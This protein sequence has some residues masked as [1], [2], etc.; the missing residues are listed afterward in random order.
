MLRRPPQS[1]RTDNSFPTR[2]SSDL[3]RYTG[4]VNEIGRRIAAVSGQPDLA[5][6]FTVIEDETPNA[7]A[8]PGGKVGV[9]TGLFKVAETD[10]QLAAVMAHEIGHAIARPSAERVSRPLLVQR[11]EDRRGGNECGSTCRP[12]RSPAY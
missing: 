10:A 5:W 4:P 9:N 3:E 11:S 7:F 1:T 6:E 2:R 12:R 8:L